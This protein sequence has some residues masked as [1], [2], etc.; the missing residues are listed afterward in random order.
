[1]DPTDYVSVL[2][3]DLPDLLI[4]MSMLSFDNNGTLEM[5]T[6]PDVLNGNLTQNQILHQQQQ[7][8][9]T[10]QQS[11]GGTAGGSGGGNTGSGSSGGGQ[12]LSE[13]RKKHIQ[14]QLVLLL[15][16]HKCNRR[17]SLNPNREK[18]TVPYCK[19]MKNV[20][21]HM[22]NCKQGRECSFQ[23]CTS[24]RQILL[25]YK[26]CT[27]SDCIICFPFR[28]QQTSQGSNDSA[29]NNAGTEERDW[30]ESVTADLRKHLVHKLFQAISDPTTMAD[31]R[32]SN[33][34][35]YAEKV[36]KDMYETAKSRSEYYH[37]LAEKIYKIQKELEEK[38]I[39]RKEQQMLIMQ[40]QQQGSGGGAGSK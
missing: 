11:G 34:V 23:H 31:K 19:S 30:R 6:M 18:C 20:L 25:H 12:H 13:E 4:T 33:L 1:M 9:C 10:S 40:Q 8:P 2:E 39:K 3:D 38:R 15:H 28:Q 36:E 22:V 14:Q 17:E 27:H 35:S 26:T 24:S 5:D 32:M 37:L 29:S 21:A 16:A 7:Q